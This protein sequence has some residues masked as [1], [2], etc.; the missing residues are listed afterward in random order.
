VILFVE[1]YILILSIWRR[2]SLCGQ[3]PNVG[4]K[5]SHQRIGFRK[6]NRYRIFAHGS[7]NFKSSVSAILLASMIPRGATK[8]SKNLKFSKVKMLPSMW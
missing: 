7:P 1:T 8:W 6:N 3:S 5:L 4:L 2:S